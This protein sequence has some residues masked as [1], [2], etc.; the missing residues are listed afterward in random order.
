[1]RASKTGRFDPRRHGAV[2]AA[3]TSD[4]VIATAARA[5]AE[6]ARGMLSTGSTLLP[7]KLHP[8]Q[9]EFV[10]DD[11]LEVLYG[12]AAGSAKST[13]LLASSLK[14]AHVPG[15]SALLLRRSYSHLTM[16]GGLIPMARE[17]L[18]KHAT[19]NASTF[20]WTFP[21]GSKVA[22]G[23]LDSDRDLDRYQGA[24][25]QLLRFDELTQFPEHHYRYLFSRLRRSTLVDVPI[26]MRAA[27]N[28]GGIGH[29]WVKRRFLI[30]GEQ[31]GRRFIPA[32][33]VDNP[34]LDREE[35]ERSLSELDPLTRATATRGRL[36]RR[37]R[38]R[39]VQA[40]LVRR[41]RAVPSATR[42][43]TRSL[44]GPCLDHSEGGHGPR[45]DV[46]RTR[47]RRPWRLVRARPSAVPRLVERERASHS[48]NGRDGRSQ[49]AGLHGARAGVSGKDV[50]DHY[51]RNVLRGYTF[52]SIRPTG[53]KQERAAP[54]ASAAEQGLVKLCSGRW[55]GDFLDE[56][57]AFPMGSHDDQVDAVSGAFGVLTC[58]ARSGLHVQG[59]GPMTSRFRKSSPS[60]R[61]VEAG[62]SMFLLPECPGCV[63]C[64][65]RDRGAHF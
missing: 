51:A 22:F 52:R 39:S 60:S 2:T 32:S 12:G 19:W 48:A 43:S 35:Y 20:T 53:N 47:R 13:A 23:Y 62:F 29:E 44:L 64:L 21:N 28:P 55:V 41:H 16:A 5:S 36:G 3:V 33:L 46:W 49:G 42:P 8:K 40:R 38:R 7:I 1:M 27:S 31:N 37:A 6:R 50:I 34:S 59:E 18:A 45:L 17:W 24:E 25:F 14:F 30:E 11:G 65:R 10:D 4:D 63:V 56:V 26:R 54:V 57:S 58:A 61:M 15:Y 9:Q